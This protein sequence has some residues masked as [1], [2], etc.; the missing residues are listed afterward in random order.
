MKFIIAF[1]AVVALRVFSDYSPDWIDVAIVVIA[2]ITDI[3]S[4][5]VRLQKKS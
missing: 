1:Y 5:V 3:V 4:G 2:L